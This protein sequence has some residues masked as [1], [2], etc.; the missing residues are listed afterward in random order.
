MK[1]N[2]NLL[3]VFLFFLVIIFPSLVTASNMDLPENYTAILVQLPDVINQ[4][5]VWNE[6]TSSVNV[7]LV[8]TEESMLTDLAGNS[9]SEVAASFNAEM[10]FNDSDYSYAYIKVPNDNYENLTESLKLLGFDVKNISWGKVLTDASRREIGLPFINP[11]TNQDVTGRGRKIAI[12]DTGI[13]PE[14]H[15]FWIDG[16]KPIN[17]KVIFWLDEVN[18]N[19]NLEDQSGHGTHIASIAAG[20]GSMSNGLFKGIAPDA[21]LII[22]RVLLEYETV[23]GVL[24]RGINDAISQ[25]P[26]VISLSIGWTEDDIVRNYEI[27][28]MD[29]CNG[30]G[31]NDIVAVSNAV[32]NAVNNGIP[33]VFAAGNEGPASGTINFPACLINAIA[34]GETFK[35]DYPSHQRDLLTEETDRFLTDQIHVIS[36]ASGATTENVN[37]EWFVFNNTHSSLI[38]DRYHTWSGFTKVFNVPNP[39]IKTQVEGK[40]K[41]KNICF[42]TEETFWNPG[43][44]SKGD[45]FWT[46]ENSL[47]PYGGVEVFGKDHINWANCPANIDQIGKIF[48]NS[49]KCSGTAASCNYFENYKQGCQAQ[50]GCNWCGCWIWDMYPLLGHCEDIPLYQCTM[51]PSSEWR[52]CEGTAIKCEDRIMDEW[53]CGTP[54]TTGCT[55]GGWNIDDVIVRQFSVKNPTLAGLPTPGSSRG[56]SANGLVKP[57]VTAPGYDICAARA[58]GTGDSELTCGNDNYVSKG[59]TSMAA[60]MVAGL[61]A[62]LKEI[63]P[64]AT[65]NEVVNAVKSGDILI[66]YFGDNSEYNRGSG[67]INISKATDSMTDCNYMNRGCPD[68]DSLMRCSDYNYNSFSSANQIRD[69]HWST[70]DRSCYC[71]VSYDSFISSV[72]ARGILNGDTF[73]S[74]PSSII[75]NISVKNT[76]Y[77][78]QGNWFVGVDFWKV[79]NYANPNG[80]KNNNVRTYFYYDGNNI[81]H[82]AY[83]GV[84]G[85]DCSLLE[86]PNSNNILDVGE[87]IK[88]SCW[89]PASYYG[90]TSGNQRIM[91]W[92]HERDL[93]R[94]A[95][96]NGNSGFTWW[97][98]ALATAD[99]AN[100]RVAIV[101][102]CKSI[103][104]VNGDGIV[105]MRDNAAIIQH[106]NKNVS[107]CPNCDVNGDGIINMR[108]INIAI[109]NFNKKCY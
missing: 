68:T 52:G 7:A 41:S 53:E 46:W 10:F 3:Y 50:G 51:K 33:V 107:T 5:D 9:L 57:D 30:M 85:A 38:Q 60:P 63:K 108:D 73:I 77:H 61:I 56:P 22:I 82:G 93:L 45:K 72:S 74:S 69:Y 95:G 37:R 87:T 1:F 27:S 105:N 6:K 71:K 11:I 25:N 4:P 31:T 23:M 104:D 102:N 39:T 84:S 18:G 29:A 12:L 32:Q 83:S 62:L 65:Y 67:R 78:S 58:A 47:S 98:D 100:L 26:D 36:T 94:D 91:F 76:G 64:T 88:L 2:F 15:D 55:S 106:F 19:Q 90:P 44:S 79:E 54:S 103:G 89:V 49:F 21:Q 28:M 40:Y 13:D 66:D 20:T 96:N 34:V 97:T 92:I 24:A 81:N 48:I 43:S 16:E 17:D 99:P 35:K 42:T 59:G 70:N 14:H 8:S 101:N 75:L 86:D 109:M 80:V